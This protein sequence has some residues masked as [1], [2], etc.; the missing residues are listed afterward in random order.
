MEQLILYKVL[1]ANEYATR[2]AVRHYYR[3]IFYQALLVLSKGNT[4]DIQEGKTFLQKHM[5]TISFTTKTRHGPFHIMDGTV[6][7]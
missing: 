1:L 5:V 2:Y 6:Y 7:H 3:D 4:N